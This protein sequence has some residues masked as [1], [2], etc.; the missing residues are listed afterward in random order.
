MTNNNLAGSESHRL[1]VTSDQEVASMKRSASHE[2]VE[3]I[4][5]AS[6]IIPTPSADEDSFADYDVDAINKD[7]AVVLV[8]ARA[9]VLVENPHGPIQ[10]RV[11]LM[12]PDS[13]NLWFA[14][15]FT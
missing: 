13:L 5:N 2:I 7:H 4:E 15:R 1:R 6:S 14:N 3:I 8:G 12:R 9:M 11:R 10:D